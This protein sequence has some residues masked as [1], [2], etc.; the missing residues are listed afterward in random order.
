MYEVGPDEFSER[1][2]PYAVGALRIVTALLFIEHGTAKL[3]GFPLT[4][5]AHPEMWSLLWIAGVFELVGGLLLLV[6]LW[7]RWVALL[8]A[9]EMAVAYWTYH[10]PQGFY[11]LLNKGEPA[12]LFCFIFLLLM[13][14]GAG[15]FSIDKIMAR[16]ASAIEGYA[17][18]GG[19][20][21]LAEAAD[22]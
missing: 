15:E 12:I 6:G 16:N 4:P 21:T 1:W 5:L 11:P 10:F 17:A 19:E 22:E 18:P 14:V 20:R 3:F 2:A 8:L 13:V 9:A 7:T